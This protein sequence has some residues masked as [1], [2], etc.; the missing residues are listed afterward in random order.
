MTYW[1]D[2]SSRFKELASMACDVFSIPITIVASESSFSVGRRALNKYMSR[3]PSDKCFS[4][5]M[6][7]ELVLE[8]SRIW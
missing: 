7:K 3:P 2:N 8:F 1:K 5:D 6:Y 4:Y